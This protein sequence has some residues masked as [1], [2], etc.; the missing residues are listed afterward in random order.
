MDQLHAL[1]GGNAAL[2]LIAAITWGGG[3]FA[4]GM[5]VKRAGGTLQAAFRTVF[6]SHGASLAVL[7]LVLLVRHESLPPT[8][9]LLWGLAA[10]FLGGTSV[11][12]FYICL[13]RGAMG[14]SAAISGLLAAAIPSLVSSLLEGAPRPLHLAGF[15]LAAAAIWLI[16]AGPQAEPAPAGTLGLSVAAGAG[17]GLYFVALRMAGAAG[18]FWPLALSRT[19]SLSVCIV[20]L[21]WMALQ[22]RSRTIPKPTSPTPWLSRRA[23]HWALATALLDTSGNLF[24]IAATRAGRLDVAAVLASL[25][26]ASTILLAAWL[27]RERPGR[28][29]AT[30]MAIAVLAV[31]LITL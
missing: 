16:A 23:V 27:L 8:A 12:C 20:G 7:L 31:V 19:V 2:A 15:L 25:Y 10:G 5:S 11:L 29:Q 28:Q 18:V 13:A 1:L 6:L 17:F 24:F 21:A 26:P 30:G 22:S 14:A 9:P 3:D 4:G